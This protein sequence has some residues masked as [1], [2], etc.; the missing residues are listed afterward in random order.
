VT[1]RP[2]GGN[3]QWWKNPL[4][5]VPAVVAILAAIISAALPTLLQSGGNSAVPSSSA[6]RG[7]TPPANGPSYSVSASSSTTPSGRATTEPHKPGASASKYLADLTPVSTYG[8]G[9]ETGSAELNGANYLNS[10]TLDMNFGSISVA[11]NLERQWHLLNATVGLRDDSTQKDEYEFQVYADGRPIYSHLFT[12]GQSRH[13]T[14]NIAGVLRLELKSTLVG[15]Y[16][17]DAFGVWGNADL[18][19]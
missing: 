15:D 5:M 19:K 6:G 9:Y 12:L 7:S 14:L 4:I 2:E 10:V 17:G 3:R 1:T 13:I 11:Y 18:T 16:Y 8:G